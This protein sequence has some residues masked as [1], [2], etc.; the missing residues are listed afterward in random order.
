MAD[1]ESVQNLAGG[2]FETASR[3]RRVDLTSPAFTTR[4]FAGAGLSGYGGD[5]GPA[6]DATLGAP[7]GLALGKDGSLFVSDTGNHRIRRIAPNGTITT[8]AGSGTY[9]GFASE[10]QGCGFAGDGGAPSEASLCA[11]LGIEVGADGTLYVADAMNN[12]IRAIRNLSSS[13]GGAG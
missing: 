9:G 8:V 1:L 6:T 11:P 5:G 7:H 12:R 10:H 4:V 2:S 3:I 13:Q